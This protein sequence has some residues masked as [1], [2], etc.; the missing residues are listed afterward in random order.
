MPNGNTF[1]IHKFSKVTL[2]LGPKVTGPIAHRR[3]AISFDI[4][5]YIKLLASA[6]VSIYLYIIP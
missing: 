4:I 2:D 1:I 6:E 3:I 5:I